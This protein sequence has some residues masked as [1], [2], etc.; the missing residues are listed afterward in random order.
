MFTDH[1][2]SFNIIIMKKEKYYISDFPGSKTT[3]INIQE[4]IKMHE[5]Y[6]FYISLFK[7]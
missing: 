1:R 7:L 5:M 3:F 4:I 2:E 6:I